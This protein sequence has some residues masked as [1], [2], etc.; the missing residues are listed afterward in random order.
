MYK[1]KTPNSNYNGITLNVKFTNGT[2]VT[3]VEE[4]KNILI[5]D[6]GYKLEEVVKS[7]NKKNA[8]LKKDGD[9]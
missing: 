9:K 5:N 7:T 3:D 8:S 4:I 6:Y 1:I 2:G